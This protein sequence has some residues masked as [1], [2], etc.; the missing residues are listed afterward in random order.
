MGGQGVAVDYQWC[1][2]SPVWLTG[3]PALRCAA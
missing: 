3:D 2:G 1:A